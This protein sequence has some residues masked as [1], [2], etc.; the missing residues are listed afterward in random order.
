MST[1]F[2][3]MKH[4]KAGGMADMIHKQ[5]TYCILWEASHIPS[6]SVG[7]IC[8]DFGFLL[9]DFPLPARLALPSSKWF[10]R[11]PYKI[12]FFSDLVSFPTD[13]NFDLKLV[14]ISAVAGE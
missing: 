12:R 9:P 3:S 1:E 8:F 4:D 10:R 6:K 13:A 2:A 14:V 7:K 11:R 5:I